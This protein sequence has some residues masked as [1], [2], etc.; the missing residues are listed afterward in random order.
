MKKSKKYKNEDILKAV[1]RGNRE[2]ELENENGFVSI[3]KV[4]KSK[5]AYTRKP[6]HK[7]S[8]KNDY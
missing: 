8:W 3:H 1:K 2:A 4:H 5:K 7:K 6:K